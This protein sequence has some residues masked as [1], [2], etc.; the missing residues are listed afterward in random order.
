M[1]EGRSMM[2]KAF[3]ESDDE[4]PLTPIQIAKNRGYR[5]E[6]RQFADYG[7]IGDRHFHRGRYFYANQKPPWW[8]RLIKVLLITFIAALLLTVLLGLLWGSF[9]LRLQKYTFLTQTAKVAELNIQKTRLDGDQLKIGLTLIEPHG[10]HKSY[11]L[12][13]LQGNKVILQDE[14]ILDPVPSGLWGLHSG[15]IIISLDVLSRQGT[16]VYS[17]QLN[18]VDND[19][20]VPARMDAYIAASKYSGITLMPSRSVYQ[21]CITST[22]LLQ[23]C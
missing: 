20:S 1:I 4:I 16:K 7:S 13:L 19:N 3:D 8:R 10:F 23:E 5:G 12:P 14:Y 6:I 2:N 21:I 17:L 9:I 15:Y 11:T 22:G 18:E